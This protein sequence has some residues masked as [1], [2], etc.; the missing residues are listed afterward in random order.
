MTGKKSRGVE[1]PAIE[2]W[3]AE[4]MNGKTCNIVLIGAQTAGRKW[5][6]YEI[7]KAWNDK[8]GVLG[9]YIHNLTNSNG[10][11]LAKGSNPFREITVGQKRSMADIVQTYDPPYIQSDAVYGYI[12]KNVESWVDGAIEIRNRI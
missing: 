11:R 8:K 9:I 6:N 4:Q 7:I 12:S 3:I 2:R 10:D 1:D 5:I